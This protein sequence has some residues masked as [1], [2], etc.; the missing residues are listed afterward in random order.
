L[1]GITE[2]KPEGNAWVMAL[3]AG[4]AEKGWTEG[5]NLQLEI[6]WPAADPSL[7]RLQA[8]ELGKIG[9]EV[10]ITHATPATLAWRKAAPLIPNVFV[11]V[12]DPIASGFVE[13]I[14]HP[15]GNS[16]GFTNFE[17]SMGGKW[18]E[19]LK[20]LWPSCA[21]AA[22]M[23]NPETFPGGFNSPHVRAIFD[24]AN[25]VGMT[26]VRLPFAD[27]ED[28]ESGLGALDNATTGLIVVLR[29][30]K[31]SNLPVQAPVKFELIINQKAAKALGIALGPTLLARADEV[32][33]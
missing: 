18:L 22:V 21:E 1:L 7:M 24:A 13:T 11:A 32:V 6:R 33:E 3:R 25:S 31:P 14:A 17:P 23:L 26:A 20:E 4:L 30:E 16:S 9:C 19:L 28:I 5:R 29:G 8:T 2:G 15:G 27:S 10:V 12:V